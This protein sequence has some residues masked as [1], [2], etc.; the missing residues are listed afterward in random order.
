MKSKWDRL[1][2][3]QAR[4]AHENCMP[5]RIGTRY[6][7]STGVAVLFNNNP[8]KR[9]QVARAKE[10]EAL[11]EQLQAAG[12]EKLGYAEYPK[13]GHQ[14]GYTYAA[15]FRCTEE[16]EYLILEMARGLFATMIPMS[17]GA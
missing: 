9:Y 12:I 3:T 13:H 7:T 5:Q 4:D 2:S 16:E 8:Y 10:F 11:A 17:D 1:A 14:A 15:I 6:L